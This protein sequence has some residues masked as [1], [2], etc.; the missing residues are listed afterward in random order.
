MQGGIIE[1]HNLSQFCFAISQFFAIFR[2]F[3]QF[4]VIFRNFFAIFFLSFFLLLAKPADLSRN[5]SIFNHL[6]FEWPGHA[7][8]ASGQS[9]MHLC[10]I[11]KLEIVICHKFSPISPQN[12]DFWNSWAKITVF[13]LVAARKFFLSP[14]RRI[15]DFIGGKSQ[16][17]AIFRNLP[18]FFCNF[19]ANFGVKIFRNF[20][21]PG[22]CRLVV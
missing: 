7:G 17:F 3:L 16:I 4:F 2:N 5:D 11:F 14:L 6:G 12:L 13:L 8:I 22:A 1:I 21:P 20:F 15:G 19:F 10:P 9:Q 18:Q